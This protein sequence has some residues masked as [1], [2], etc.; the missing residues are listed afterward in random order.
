DTE[1]ICFREHLLPFVHG[2]KEGQD[3]YKGQM[4]QY[5]GR[6]ELLKE[7]L[8]KGTVDLK[9]FHV[10]LADGGNFTCFVQHGSDYDEAVVELKVTAGG[11][12]PLIALERYQDGGIRVGCRSAGWYPQPQVLWQD[13]RGRHLPS[14]SERVTQDER[15][16]F[17]AESSIILSRGVSQQLSCSVRHARHGH[18]RASALYISDPFFQNAHPWMTAFAVVLVA[19]V[20]LLVI[21]VYL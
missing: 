6:T 5:R 8:A 11:S 13:P 15:G 9:I 3:Q 17:A 12:A 19:A 14:L 20:A 21:A 7:G 16:L 2:Y 1:V 18:E 10:E 4:L